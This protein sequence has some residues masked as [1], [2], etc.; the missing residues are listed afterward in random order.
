MNVNFEFLGEEP[1]E[2]LI[3]CMNFQIDKVVFFGYKEIIEKQRDIIDRFLKNY[4][5]VRLIEFCAVYQNDLDMT[6]NVMREK[7]EYEYKQSN[8]IYFDIT[9]GESLIL[10]AFGMLSREFMAPMHMFDIPMN[11]LM[12]F[13]P[14]KDRSISK[15]VKA[16]KTSM[17][18]EQ[19]IEMH[20][21]RINDSLQKSIKVNSNQEFINDVEKMFN[22]ANRYGDYWNAFSELLRSTFV[23]V[24]EN[25]EVTQTTSNVKKAL[26]DINSKLN[27]VSILNEILDK[28]YSIGVL[29]EVIH[30]KTQYS[31]R[32]KNKEIKDCLWETGTILELHTFYEERE[33][34]D[35]C[36][37]GVHIDWDGV[38]HIQSNTDVTN[39]VDVLSLTGYTPTFISCKS[40][41][42][43]AQ[44][45]LYAL[46]ELDTVA[47]RFG[48]KYA[49]KVLV[50]AKGVNDIYVER[51][52]E[53]GIE[54]R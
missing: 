28:L 31:F 4:C 48:G 21:G 23:P 52:K 50:T 39:E 51:A 1:I 24:D 37:V 11:K 3:T 34:C 10:V 42:M 22:I 20:G 33:Q 49:R 6:L 41:K 7:I 25:L 36:R 14:S 26:K 5:D 12:E 13:G 15:E 27:T 32:F 45:T 53:M 44:Q 30:T 43:G 47:S 16:K 29:K 46:Y 38:L 54:I 17:T 35:E 18:L 8:N 19:L 9:G 2:N 40:G